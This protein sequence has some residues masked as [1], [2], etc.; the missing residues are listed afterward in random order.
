MGVADSAFRP[1]VVVPDSFE[2]GVLHAV[3][4]AVIIPTALHRA[5]PHTLPAMTV[6]YCVTT[7][8]PK[9]RFAAVATLL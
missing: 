5:Y 6:R 8:E 3:V 4:H 9:G 2:V 7:A 1:V